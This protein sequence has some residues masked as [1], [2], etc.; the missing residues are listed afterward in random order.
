M[1]NTPVMPQASDISRGLVDG[2]DPLDFIKQNLQRPQPSQTPQPAQATA[3]EQIQDAIKQSFVDKDTGLELPFDTKQTQTPPPPEQPQE[4]EQQQQP[5]K[6]PEESIKNLRKKANELSKLVEERGSEAEQ[7]KEQLEKYKT[8]EALPDVIEQYK[9]RISELERYEQLHA[10]RMSKN[11]AQKYVE[12][13][14]QLKT[15]AISIAEEYGVNPAILDKAITLPNRKE[16]NSFLSK[17]FD[18]VGAL[19]VREALDGIKKLSIEAQQAEAEPAQTLENL[20]QE[21]QRHEQAQ[22]KERVTKISNTAKSSWVEALTELRDGEQ[23]PELQ[24]TG[25]EEHD[26]YVRPILNEAAAEYGKFVK[27]LGLTGAKELRPEAAKILAKRYLLSQV[28]AIAM[29]SR[30]QHYKRAE[31]LINE[32]KRQSQFIRPPVGGGTVSAPMQDNKKPSSPSEAA[33]YLL[34]KIGMR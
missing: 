34:Q 22:E 4:G 5:D 13:I 26:K 19:E 2:Q 24:L 16:L 3:T 32:S 30:T 28:A 11:Y 12:P 23:Y 15:K 18:E 6:G 31:E 20:R 1:I 29:E 33:D 7:L 9:T 27:E 21:Q 14:E 17:H 10:L 8:G 25:N